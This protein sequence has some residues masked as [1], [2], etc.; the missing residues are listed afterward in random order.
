MTYS[1]GLFGFRRALFR[2]DKR[3]TINNNNCIMTYEY[4]TSSRCQ[5]RAGQTHGE[6]PVGRSGCA[7]WTR[8]RT[9][10]SAA[11]S[12]LKSRLSDA[13][14]LRF[15]SQAGRVTGKS[16]PSLWRDEHPAIKGL[17]PPAS[18]SS[19]ALYNIIVCFKC[20]F[21]LPVSCVMFQT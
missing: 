16:T 2:L 7:G 8:R 10:S 17:R 19:A 14:G 12:C 13:G 21:T 5:D 15:E 3:T 11:L 6:A 18:L 20:L 4:I 1:S 9:I